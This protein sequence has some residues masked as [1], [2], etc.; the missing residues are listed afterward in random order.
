M[1]RSRKLFKTENNTGERTVLWGAPLDIH[2]ERT[3][4]LG[5]PLDI[6]NERDLELLILT[7][8]FIVG[9]L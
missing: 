6:H 5:A 7:C 8:N 2:N 3:V 9:L 4:P 1:L